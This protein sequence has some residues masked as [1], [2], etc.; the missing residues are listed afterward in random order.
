[1]WPLRPASPS[2]FSCGSRFGRKRT[3]QV[4]DPRAA[5]ASNRPSP[6]SHKLTVAPA[7]GY[8]EGRRCHRSHPAFDPAPVSSASTAANEVPAG[9]RVKATRSRKPRSPA[10]LRVADAE[11]G[12][13]TVPGQ[14]MQRNEGLD[15]QP[16]GQEAHPCHERSDP[17]VPR[18]CCDSAQ[19][20]EHRQSGPRPVGTPP[21]VI[22]DEDAI[23]PGSLP[24]HLL[25]RALRRRSARTS[26][27]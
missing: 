18:R 10:T 11:R 20:R 16:V 26:G 8:L 5:S 12:H 9:P 25:P 17:D 3:A 13:Q 6:T 22:E 1:M 19:H 7:M 23:D 24:R 4:A 14:L 15:H 27:G 2:A 21:E